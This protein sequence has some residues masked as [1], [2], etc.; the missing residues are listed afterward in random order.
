M[1]RVKTCGKMNSVA[2]EQSVCLC[3]QMII[4]ADIGK[5]AHIN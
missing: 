5:R 3:T 2:I 1:N 4:P